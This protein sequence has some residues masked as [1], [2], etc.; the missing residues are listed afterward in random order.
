MKKKIFMAL[1]ILLVIAGA[2]FAQDQARAKNSVAVQFGV[3][4][5]EAG[6]ERIIN[7]FFSVLADVSYTN[8]AIVDEFTV[9]AKGR[10]YPFG[11][12]FYLEMGAGFAYGRS[13]SNF[14]GTMILGMLT[15]GWYFTQIDDDTFARTGG[16]LLQPG[17]GWK[18]DIGKQDHFV[19]Q[20]S[21]GLD[22]KAGSRPDIL[23]YLRIGV[24]YSF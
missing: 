2:V 17:L 4:S 22:I 10:V 13:F 14:V 16:L 24:G 18:I 23:P 5:V 11:R 9:A 1:I 12:A 21:M 15:F 3:I 7:R 20:I 6:Y 19:L 8:L